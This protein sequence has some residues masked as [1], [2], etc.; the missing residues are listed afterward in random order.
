MRIT[1]H[2]A[3]SHFMSAV[4]VAALFA[5][6]DVRQEKRRLSEEFEH[7]V[8]V[9]GKNLE[10]SVEPLLGEGSSLNLQEIVEKYGN[11]EWLKGVAAYD[12]NDHLL[13]VS[14]GL[15]TQPLGF[16]ADALRAVHAKH[17]LGQFQMMDDKLM[18]IEVLPLNGNGGMTGALLIIHDV[19][20][21]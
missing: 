14:S 2:L 3:L 19:S 5:V 8:A 6:L 16:L 20:A 21:I 10:R 12:A 9:L 15:S 11:L 7:R 1:F 4:L 13:A 17:G 18:H